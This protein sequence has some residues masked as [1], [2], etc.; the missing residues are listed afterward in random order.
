MIILTV[1]VNMSYVVSSLMVAIVIFFAYKAYHSE[2]DFDKSFRA[3]VAIDGD[4]G[5]GLEDDG[6]GYL[7]LYGDGY[8]GDPSSVAG[9]E[10]KRDVLKTGW[11]FKSRSV[12]GPSSSHSSMRSSVRSSASSSTQSIITKDRR[13]F[14]LNKAGLGWY[15]SDDTRKKPCEIVGLEH[16][17]ATQVDSTPDAIALR[18][19]DTSVHKSW[20]FRAES[21]AETLRWLEALNN[22]QPTPDDSNGSESD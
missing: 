11:M 12:N 9:N 1:I 15:R 17:T 13:F 2:I 3:K 21:N 18:P 7:A 10:D 20:Y 14:I 5:F 6:T 22:W 8:D 19:I 4:H 16:Y